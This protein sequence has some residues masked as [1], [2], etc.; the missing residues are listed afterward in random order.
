MK[1]KIS[2][3]SLFFILLIVSLISNIFV[4]V[5]SQSHTS[6]YSIENNSSDTFICYMN[7]ITGCYV[8]QAPEPDL[9]PFKL[10]VHIPISFGKQAPFIFNLQAEPKGIVLDFKI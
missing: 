1:S 2:V 8:V 5:T 9:G 7:N 6:M 3:K 4:D 10:Y